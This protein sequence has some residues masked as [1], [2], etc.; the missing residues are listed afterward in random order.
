MWRNDLGSHSGN[1]CKETWG[2]ALCVR[3]MRAMKV[4]KITNLQDEY[5]ETK[6]GINIYF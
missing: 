4:E 3:L 5:I 6:I 2:T 1:V